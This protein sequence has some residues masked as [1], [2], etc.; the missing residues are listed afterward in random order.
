MGSYNGA[1]IG[2]LAASFF[3]IQLGPVIDKN[4]IG[5]CCDDGIEVFREIS[6]PMIEKKKKT[7]C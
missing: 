5:F 1:E 3:I 7:N 6:K 4:D 2:G